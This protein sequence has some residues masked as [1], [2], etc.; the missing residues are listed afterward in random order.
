MAA[1]CR[2]CGSAAGGCRRESKAPRG[3]SVARGRWRWACWRRR[4]VALT[5]A[6]ACAGGCRGVGAEGCDSRALT[7]GCRDRRL[8]PA[9]CSV[10][11]C[12]VFPCVLCV[13]MRRAVLRACAFVSSFW[14]PDVCRWASLAFRLVAPT[15]LTPRQLLP[16]VAATPRTAQRSPF[17]EA[18]GYVED[19]TLV[20]VR[21]WGIPATRTHQPRGRQQLSTM[22]SV[23]LEGAPRC[24]KAARERM[25]LPVCAKTAM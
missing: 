17:P 4:A 14:V 5:A 18:A 11:C 25:G 16:C 6:A 20:H 15:S 22:R 9:V 10:V 21:V 3:C 12:V 13:L 2:R 19:A 23:G 1:G 8:L 7:R 24:R